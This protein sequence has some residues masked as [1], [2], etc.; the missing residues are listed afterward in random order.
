VAIAFSSL[1]G[2]VLAGG[3]PVQADTGGGVEATYSESNGC[4]VPRGFS[5]LATRVGALSNSEPIRGPFGA[6]F[7]RTIGQVRSA[8][9]GWTVPFTGGLSISVHQRALPA[10]L[11]VTANLSASGGSYPTRTSQTH[12]YAARTVSGS[13]SISY[14][15]YGAAVDINSGSNIERNDGV[16]ITDMPPWY[17]SA[18]SNAG[19]CWGGLWTND[20]KD[21]MHYSWMGPLATPGYGLIPPPYPSLAARAPFATNAG[22]YAVG[23]GARRSGAQDGLADLTGD[24]SIDAVRIKTH[25]VAGPIVEVMGAWADF[26]MCG[27]ARFQLPGADPTRPVIFGNTTYGGR[28]DVVFLDLGASTVNMQVYEASLFYEQ[29]HTVS[30]AA[31][32]QAGATYLLADSDADGRADLFVINGATVEV[33]SAASGYTARVATANLAGNQPTR[34]LSGDRDVDG[35]ADLYSIGSDGSMQILTAASGYALFETVSLGTAPAADEVVRVSDYDGD[36]HGDLYRLDRNGTMTVLLGN[37]PIYSDLD[38]WFRAPDFVCE[39]GGVTYDFTGR[40]ADDE[41]NP[42]LVD[43]EWAAAEGVT[44]GCNPPFNDWFC[45]TLEVTR[46]Q[47]ATFLAR[48]R[49][50][51]DTTVDAFTD[52]AGSPHEADINRVA[53]AGITLGCGPG[54]YCPGQSVTREQMASFLV[55]AYDLAPAT[56][57]PFTDVFSGYHAADVAALYQAGITGGCSVSPPLYCPSAAVLREQMAAFLHRAGTS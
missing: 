30:T 17:V 33:W 31:P 14:H 16:L 27:F 10:F 42:F 38:G 57:N 3:L 26:G 50:L 4:G 11:Q 41:R 23:L 54:S 12:G 53:A 18:W 51:P 28:A 34:V 7:G 22:T 46:A 49:A 36:G 44:V 29:S 9:V 35:R 56:T 47:M 20:H 5:A 15:A 13:R 8:L 21:P 37:Q 32:A 1:V 19:F 25:P 45:P 6:L 2:S 43:I 40:F 48:A 52:D 24:G 39:P 55:R